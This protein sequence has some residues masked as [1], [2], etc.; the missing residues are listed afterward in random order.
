M[1]KRD[2]TLVSAQK[3]GTTLPDSA[4]RV[5]GT[6]RGPASAEGVCSSSSAGAR[7]AG[8]GRPVTMP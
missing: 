4:G 7:A 1:K 3:A 5:N 6:G 8:E 2:V